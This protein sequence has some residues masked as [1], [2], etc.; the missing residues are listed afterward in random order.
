MASIPSSV[1]PAV[2]REPDPTP[3]TAPEVVP[4]VG[5]AVA[6]LAAIRQDTAQVAAPTIDADPIPDGQRR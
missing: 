4:A 2:P 3:K 5:G 6:A 1:R